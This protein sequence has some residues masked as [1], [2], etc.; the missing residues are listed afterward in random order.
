MALTGTGVRIIVHQPSTWDKGNLFGKIIF[1]RAGKTLIV[2]LS[3]A[4]AGKQLTSDLIELTAHNEADTF[5]S[6]TQ[7]YSVMIDGNLIDESRQ[8]KEPIIYGSVTFD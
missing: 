2:R 8:V 6:L 1:D 5:K 3:E 7:Y 4:I